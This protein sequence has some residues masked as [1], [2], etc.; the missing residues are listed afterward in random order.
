MGRCSLNNFVTDEN[1]TFGISDWNLP[2]NA[3]NIM[4]GTNEQWGS[5]DENGNRKV[6]YDQNQKEAI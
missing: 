2:K 1:E 4:E 6:I 3:E 5:F